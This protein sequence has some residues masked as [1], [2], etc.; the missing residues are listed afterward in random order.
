MNRSA[1]AERLL[2]SALTFRAYALKV[3]LTL[4]AIPVAAVLRRL[5]S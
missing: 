2:V 3:L 1:L 4:A 5:E